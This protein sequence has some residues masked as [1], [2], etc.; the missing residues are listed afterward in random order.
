MFEYASAKSTVLHMT[1]R[2]PLPSYQT[3]HPAN[4]KYSNYVVCYNVLVVFNITGVG[5]FNIR[6]SD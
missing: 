5:G 6:G 1:P 2:N 4:M 3:I